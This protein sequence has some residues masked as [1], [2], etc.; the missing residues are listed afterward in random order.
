M[1]AVDYFEDE[2]LDLVFTNENIANVGDATGL[3]KSTADG[4]IQ[5]S[6]ATVDY[7]DADTLMTADEAA[8]TNYAR[9]T[10]ARTTSGW[11]VLTG[12]VDN[13]AAVSFPSSGSGPET[14][15][16]FGLALLATGDIIALFGGLDSDLV[17]NSGV[18]PE[19]AAGALNI[20]LA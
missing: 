11:T 17:V 15:V 18:V 13:D 16:A 4:S 20:T 12:T 6:L 3:V 8:Y 14:E 19:F 10:V 5:V 1:S 7:I 2:L 9:Q